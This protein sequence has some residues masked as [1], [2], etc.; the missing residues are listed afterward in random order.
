MGGCVPQE[1]ITAAGNKR[2]EEK[3]WKYG[4]MEATYEGVQ[5]SEGAVAPYMDG[6]SSMKTRIEILD[7]HQKQDTKHIQETETTMIQVC[8]N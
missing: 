4:W 7:S 3:S 2:M 8:Y 1:C 5:G 6:I